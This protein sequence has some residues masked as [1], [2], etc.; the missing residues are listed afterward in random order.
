MMPQVSFVTEQ[1]NGTVWIYDRHTGEAEGP[2]RSAIR[3]TKCDL[4]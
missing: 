3:N 4:P 2:R 1:G